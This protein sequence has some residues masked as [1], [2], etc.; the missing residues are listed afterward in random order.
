MSEAA[1]CSYESLLQ[2]SN[3][4]TPDSDFRP[5]YVLLANVDE[6]KKRT[7]VNNEPS[8]SL[9]NDTQSVIGLLSPVTTSNQRTALVDD[10]QNYVQVVECSQ[11]YLQVI[12]DGQDY[13]QPCDIDANELLPHDFPVDRQVSLVMT[14]TVVCSR[15]R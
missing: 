4:D 8:S 1:S 6:A 11:D 9:E 15:Y 3:S 5:N 10:S 14:Y 7:I 12:E 13:L 2:L